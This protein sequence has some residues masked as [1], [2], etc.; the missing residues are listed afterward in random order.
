[1]T[2]RGVGMDIVDVAG[3][4]SQVAESGT[5]FEELVFT[6]YELEVADRLR[7]SRRDQF[8]A[9]RFAVKEALVKAWFAALPTGAPV[10]P[11]TETW[12]GIEV[13][14]DHLGRPHL[15]L[16]DPVSKAF[17]DSMGEVALHVSLSHETLF[18]SAVVIIDDAA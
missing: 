11:E 10:L 5:V 18:A 8:L 6:A 1:M 2:V 13:H 9:S 7:G 16:L 15:S 4:A 17:S 14:N 3:F 12:A